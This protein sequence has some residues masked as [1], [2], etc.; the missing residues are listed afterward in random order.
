MRPPARWRSAQRGGEPSRVVTSAGYGCCVSGRRFAGRAGRRGGA[1][2]AEGRL[3]GEDFL[4]RRG[5]VLKGQPV[6]VRVEAVL[7]IA[8]AELD[9]GV[10][11][12]VPPVC[13]SGVD[14]VVGLGSVVV[15]LEQRVV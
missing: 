14:V 13:L 15:H 1:G 11:P 6:V 4:D 8:L 5:E 10:E 3:A 12:R 9:R 7:V 2:L